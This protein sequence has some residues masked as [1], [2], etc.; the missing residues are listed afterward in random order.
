MELKDMFKNFGLKARNLFKSISHYIEKLIQ[1]VTKREVVIGDGIVKR[2]RVARVGL[3]FLENIGVGRKIGAGYGIVTAIIL[4]V[5]LTSIFNFNAIVK[6]ND[7]LKQVIESE[8]QMQNA[9]IAMELYKTDRSDESAGQVYDYLNASM[10]SIEQVKALMKNT[11][12]DVDEFE[13]QLQVFNEEFTKYIEIDKSKADQSRVQMSMGDNVASDIKA[14]MDGAQFQITLATDLEKVPEAFEQYATIQKAFDA[15]NDVRIA[16]NKYA[17]SESESYLDSLRLNTVKAKEYLENAESNASSSSVE[18][19]IGIA[20]KSFNRYVKSFE[21]FETLILEQS[22]QVEN[23]RLA[24]ETTSHIAEMISNDV[25]INNNEIVSQATSLS[26][27]AMIIG[28]ILSILIAIGLTTSITGPLNAIV[29]QMKMIAEYNLTQP[30]SKKL[31]GRR[32]EMGRLAKRSEEI[33]EE[34]LEIISEIS[35]ASTSVSSASNQLTE[36]GLKALEVGHDVSFTVEEIASSARS[37]AQVT[38]AGAN[39]ISRL[40]ELIEE[41]LSQVASLT[42]FAS[43][44]ENLK[45]EGI[46]ILD[47]LVEETRFTNEATDSVQVIVDKTNASAIKIEKASEL[48]AGIAKQTNLLALNAAIEAARAGDAGKGF[49]VVAEEIRILASQ[50][51]RFTKEI[52]IDIA[53]LKKKSSQAVV[54]MEK[55]KEAI[56][57]QEEDVHKT[58]E[59]YRGIAEAIGSMK[60][61]ILSLHNFGTEMSL[62]MDGINELILSLSDISK[63]NAAGSEQATIGMKQQSAVIHDVSFY[64]RELT[65][66][67][68][69]MDHTISLFKIT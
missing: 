5:A 28:T 37:Q 54:T 45:N 63:A 64:S 18:E 25:Q 49:A 58:S 4:L 65:Q 36:T 39:E 40:S 67:A 15:F 29:D 52:S 60:H 44:V 24:V 1:K 6:Q 22:V 48:I 56:R 42:D 14:T 17:A 11:S 16:A 68:Q 13:A 34:L 59:K 12:K 57:K 30:I 8:N 9:R 10:V 41:D 19:N 61:N 27:T 20:L 43:H 23:M 66:L 62:Q 69:S 35:E 26:F 2:R 51:D 38:D 55:A 47:S 31:L 7:L 33:R 50:T 32:D 3:K 21:K 46:D 53:D